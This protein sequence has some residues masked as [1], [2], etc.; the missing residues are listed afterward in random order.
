VLLRDAVD[1]AGAG[2]GGLGHAAAALALLALPVLVLGV[3]WYAKNWLVYGNPLYPFAM[4][5]FPGPTTLTEFTFT[6]PQL[7]GRSWLGQLASSWTADW[8]LRRYAYNVRPGGLG[9][10]WP[11][12]LVIAAA[13]LVL[14]A[15]RRSVAPIAF[16]LVPAAATLVTMPMPWY[17]R[18]TLFL[19]AIALP[20]A[21]LAIDAL[22]PRLA[23]IAA[24]ALVAVAAVSLTFANARPNIDI[25]TGTPPRL[26]SVGQYLSFVLTAEDARRANVSLRAECARFDVIPPGSV[27]APG[28][29]NL[30][31]APVGPNLDRIL[32]DPL[33]TASDPATLAATLRDRGAGWLVTS[34]G[35]RPD[36][37][38]ASAPDVFKP[39]GAIC[40]GG[41]LYQLV[42]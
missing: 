41:R 3:S 39:Y 25:Q 6:P 34:T 37:I 8:S 18:L 24:L 31:H 1:R 40:Q 29:F 23:T 26:A 4:G 33:P 35:G 15:R 32:G 17:A 36:A 2:G 21:A 42:R 9:A 19:P 5:P 27:V 28:G 7:E 11:A 13:G 20:V 38:A 10:A 16:V 30:L 22:R 12:I 14:L